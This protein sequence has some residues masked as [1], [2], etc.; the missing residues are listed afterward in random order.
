MELEGVQVVLVYGICFVFL[1]SLIVSGFLPV[2]SPNTDGV[3]AVEGFLRILAF[4]Q[5]GSDG[6]SEGLELREDAL[7]LCSPRVKFS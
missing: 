5:W 1:S 2:A 7:S 6:N 3:N 4:R